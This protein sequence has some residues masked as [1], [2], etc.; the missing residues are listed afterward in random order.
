M[1]NDSLKHINLP[2]VDISEQTERHVIIPAQPV[3]TK[4]NSKLP[5]DDQN[6]TNARNG[7]HDAT[8][9]GCKRFLTVMAGALLAMAAP[10]WAQGGGDAQY[11]LP[12]EQM[13]QLQI[14]RMSKPPV[15]DGAIEGEEWQEAVAVSGVGAFSKHQLIPRPTTFFLGWDEGH[16][17]FAVRAYVRP[18]YKPSIPNGRSE[19][20][21]YVF[22]DGMELGWWPMGRNVP[23][24]K[25]KDSFKLFLNC[26]GF[27]GDCSRNSLG[28]QFKN[29]NPRFT[30]KTRITEPGTAPDG[31][32][33]WELEM[34][35]T[36]EDFELAGD[37]RAGDPWRLMLAF[38]HLP[39]APWNQSRIPCAGPFLDPFGY[40][41]TTLVENKPS[42]QMTMDSLQNLATDGT[43]SMRIKAHNPTAQPVSLAVNIEV[44]RGEAAAL[45]K[46]ETLTVQPG[47]TAELA[48][49]EKAP[50]G[51]KGGVLS[52]SVKQGEEEIYRYGIPYEVGFMS[53]LLAPV[54]PPDP[55]KFNFFAQFNP[56]RSWLLVKGDT[57]YLPD[58]SKAK[59]LRYSVVPEAGGGSTG[60]TAGKPVTEGV[61]TEQ[62]SEYF[63]QKLIELPPLKPGKYLV[64]ATMSVEG[65]PDRGPMTATIVKKD[66]AK[67]FPE[68]WGKKFGDV[69]RV[70]PPYTGVKRRGDTVSVILRDYQLSALGL[71]VSITAKDGPV[72]AAPARLV[73]VID[74]QEHT[75]PLGKPRFTKVTDW[76]VEFEG[77][78]KVAGLDV[79]A[80][81]WVEQDGL[82]YVD[83]TYKPA[84]KAP[85]TLEALRI[86]YPLAEDDADALVC[87]GPGGNFSSRTTMLLPKAGSSTL[88]PGPS[89]RGRG[90]ETQERLWSTLG[91][92]ITGSG[93]TVGSFYPTVWIGSERRGFLWWGDNDRGWVQESSVPAHEAVRQDGAVVLINN[94]VAKPTVL[95]EPRT[96]SFSYIATPFKPLPKGWRATIATDNGTFWQPF[97]GVRKDSKTG[98]YIFPRPTSGHHNMIHPESRYPEEWPAL[99]AEQKEKADAHARSL[100]WIDPYGARSGINFTHMSFQIIGYGRKSLQNDLYA[101]FGPEWEGDEDTW[102]ESYTDYAMYLFSPAFTDG[103]VRHTYWDLAFPRPYKNPLG[104]LSYI[105]PDGREQKGYNGWNMRRFFMRLHALQVDAGLVPGANGFHSS[106]AYLPIAMP[107]VDSVLDGER[108]WD[109]DSSPEDWVDAMS[110][111]RMRS[112]SS[113]HNWGVD[114]CWMAVMESKEHAKVDA[115]YRI[116]SQWVR[117]HDSWLNTQIKKFSPPWHSRMPDSVLDWGLNEEGI[118]YHP[119]WRNPFVSCADK[120]VLVSLWHTEGRAILGVF[121]YA[122]DQAKDAELKVDLAKLGLD[123][124]QAYARKLWTE[125]GNDASVELNR[126]GTLQVKA[127]PGHRL[128]LVGLAA[129]AATELER[130]TKALPGWVAGGL[131]Q[132][133]MDFGLVRKETK[134]FGPGQAPGVTCEN[135]A[136]QVA[137]WQLPDRVLLAVYNADEKA[138]KDAV[139]KVDLAALGLKQ[140][141]IW[142]EFVGVRQLYAEEKAPAPSLDYYGG[143]LTLRG[144]PAQGGRLVTIRRY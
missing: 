76:R 96:I 60:L 94:I 65:A 141:L 30:V 19:G 16:L 123:P 53:G 22:D 128:I 101:Y 29:W 120:D 122:K 36:P 2:V 89:P 103:G 13:P 12:P 85:V 49:N 7:E 25:K 42:V 139:L 102:N 71:P 84:G 10:V 55:A 118:V 112:L 92:G 78:T 26:L 57:Y 17:Y 132:S 109:L 144:I 73:V 86:E 131:P 75:A 5:H 115:A 54:T 114:I 127:L 100:Q 50:E 41:L 70:L 18:G 117:M 105:L 35:A 32:S 51:V 40:T 39:N 82:V 111:E 69:E 11:G 142:Q 113:P 138:A 14:P 31:G 44:T 9:N 48:L 130:A 134:H 97:R 45:T 61:I 64:T 77:K 66:E 125:P 104:G 58:P 68:W 106:N 1:K 107:W 62:S 23:A 33:W 80:K 91:T 83:L 121:N 110:S 88:T 46:T 56:V 27:K 126:D 28:Q 90:E 119:Y 3:H 34:S 37:H 47:K 116:Q 6:A 67:E 135:A 79:T 143:T 24:D 81:G 72:S 99:W 4:Q 74:G 8:M 15:I 98:E 21:A 124:K 95:S 20:L 59:E 38:N 63:M 140:K 93:M 133:V 87:I 129:P 43:A 137:M 108:N 52:V 136:I